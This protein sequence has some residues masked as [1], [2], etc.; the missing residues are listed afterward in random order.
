MMINFHDHD[1]LMIF[2]KIVVNTKTLGTYVACGYM[3]P[4][5]FFNIT[6]T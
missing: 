4:G 2:K 1:D 6:G 5:I 3:N